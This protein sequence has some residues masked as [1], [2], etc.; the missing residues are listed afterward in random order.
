MSFLATKN[1]LAPG[2]ESK[3]LISMPPIP[4]FPA[5][6]ASFINA[7]PA[8]IDRAQRVLDRVE[9]LGPGVAIDGAN[10]RLHAPWPHRRIACVGGNYAAH[11]QGMERDRPGNEGATLEQI[12]Q[13]TREAGQ[14][15]FL[16]SARMK[17][18]GPDDV[19]SIPQARSAV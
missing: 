13:R 9:S 8:A 16:E 7:G 4:I 14:W 6:L 2:S 10:V 3:S 19:D 11:L 5:D 15:G 12:T 18:A 17:L 1:E